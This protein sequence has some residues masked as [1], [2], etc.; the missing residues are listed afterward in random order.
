MADYKL[1]YTGDQIAQRLAKTDQ[2]DDKVSAV[3][4]EQY[5]DQVGE[6]IDKKLDRTGNDLGD[7][8]TFNLYAKGTSGEL[9]GN[10]VFVMGEND[11]IQ[12]GCLT[13][14]DQNIVLITEEDV[15]IR[16]NNKTSAIATESYVDEKL[17]VIEN[18]S[19]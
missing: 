4:Y 5:K 14:Q 1:P 9:N 16:R 15:Y 19:Y 13:T 11:A 10:M 7:I 17:G 12:L 2:I 6:K 18:G 8:E 3:E